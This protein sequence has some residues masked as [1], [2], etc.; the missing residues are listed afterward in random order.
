MILGFCLIQKRVMLP[1]IWKVQWTWL[2][3]VPSVITMAFVSSNYSTTYPSNIL[4]VGSSYRLNFT[5]FYGI[6]CFFKI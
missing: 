5:L 4:I 2:V 3:A 1:V 6:F